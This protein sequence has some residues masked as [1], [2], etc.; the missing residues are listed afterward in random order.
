[1]FSKLLTFTAALTVFASFGPDASWAKDKILVTIPKR[2]ELTPVQRLNRAGVDATR[3]HEYNKAA[4]LFYKAY[5]YD[6]SDPFT[7]NNIGYISEVQGELERARKFYALASEQGSD[8]R[9][10]RS[11]AKQLEGKPMKFAFTSLQDIPMRVNRMNVDAI[12]L[13]SENRAFEAVATLERAMT[14]DPLNPF[15]RNNLGVAYEAVGDYDNAMK[16][17]IAVADLHSAEPVVVTIDHTWRG[18]PISSMAAQSAKQLQDRMAKMEPS[19]ANA[20]MFAVRG[21]AAENQNDWSLAREAFIHAYTLDPANAFS[22]NNRGY[23]AERDGDPE[24][25]KFFYDKAR[26][27]NDSNA[28]VGLATQLSAEGKKLMTVAVDSTQQVAVELNKYRED[29]HRQTGPIELTPRDPQ[30]TGTSLE[31]PDDHSPL[32]TPSASPSDI[33]Q[34]PKD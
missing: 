8:A 13:L 21:V 10:D 5:L 33:A 14:L 11:S 28:R 19:Q 25:A 4:T 26:N 32:S 29:R 9:I 18:R 30:P 12:V 34:Y 31:Q 6:P 20:E 16:N 23:V 27:A 1:M 7:L 3:K 17:Y 24:T 2:S 15:T 22:L